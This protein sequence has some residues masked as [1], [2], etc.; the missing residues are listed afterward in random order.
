ML[1]EIDFVSKL[2]TR[3]ERDYV[4]R[5]NA[6]DKAECATIAKQY[7]ED[8]WDG[9]RHDGYGGYSYDCR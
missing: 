6:H 8:Y 9:A 7:G 5:V 4:G 1:E 2:H 3:T